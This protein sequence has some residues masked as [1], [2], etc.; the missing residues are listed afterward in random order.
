[1]SPLAPTAPLAVVT[2]ASSGIGAELAFQLATSGIRVLAVARRSDRLDQLAARA[3]SKSIATIHTLALDLTATNATAQVAYAARSLGG[4]DWLVNDAG[5]NSFGSFRDSNPEAIT[6]MIRL[7]CEALVGMTH[8]LL[9]AMLERGRGVVLNVSSVAG[10]VPTPFM[11]V[12]GAT[13]AFVLS[14]SEALRAELRGTGVSVTALCPG[15]VS[16]DIY[17]LSAPGVARR[18]VFNE[19]TAEACAQY[20]IA[21]ARR[22]SAIAVPGLFNRLNLLSAKLAP[23]GLVRWLLKAQGLSYLGYARSTFK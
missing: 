14:Y 13:K 21:A 17:A 1:M 10:F 18:S 5:I 19:M 9:P 20:G 3:R 15:P 2:G 16:T 6:Q 8:A 23:R 22:G 4:A 7:N 11:A 12:Y